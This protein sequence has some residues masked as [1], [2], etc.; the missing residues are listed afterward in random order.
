MEASSIEMKQNLFL[1]KPYPNSISFSDKFPS[2]Y[3]P[4]ED[5]RFKAKPYTKHVVGSN[6][7]IQKVDIIPK[8]C[9]RQIRIYQRCMIAN[10]DRNDVCR[11]EQDNIMNICPAFALDQ[12]RESKLLLLKI[13]GLDNQKYRRAMEVPAYNKGRTVADIPYRTWGDGLPQNLRPS[14]LWAD[15]RYADVTEEQIKAAQERV[16]KRRAANPVKPYHNES[17]NRKYEVPP[18]NNRFSL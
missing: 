17:Y 2:H 4:L 18:A 13:E 12:L 3:D 9:H 16:N 7:S 10:D 1:S 8:F 14:T 6:P 5:E 11:E 15:D